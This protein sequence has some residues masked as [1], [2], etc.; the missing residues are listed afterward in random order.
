[1]E[2]ICGDGA[3]CELVCPIMQAGRVCPSVEIYLDESSSAAT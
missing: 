1:M 2:K 3:A